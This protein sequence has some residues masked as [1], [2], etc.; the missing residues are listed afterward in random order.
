MA[1]LFN[2]EPQTIQK[3]KRSGDQAIEIKTLVLGAAREVQEMPSGL[4]MIRYVVA[5]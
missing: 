2:P 5:A 1:L 3:I 4:V